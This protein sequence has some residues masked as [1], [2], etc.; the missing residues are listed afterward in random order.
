MGA[1]TAGIFLVLDMVI[2]SRGFLTWF[3][4]ASWGT[5]TTLKIGATDGFITFNSALTL[6][7][8][9]L[10]FLIVTA[11]LLFLKQEVPTFKEL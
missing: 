5:L 1:F 2:K 3:S 11:N 8:I 9:I 6:Y 10:G 4:P 7:A